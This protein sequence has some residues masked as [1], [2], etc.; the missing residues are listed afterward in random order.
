MFKP[1]SF[2][3]I[4]YMDG[5]GQRPQ[6]N[7]ATGQW[8]ET[9]LLYLIHEHEPKVWSK[10]DEEKKSKTNSTSRKPKSCAHY[11]YCTSTIECRVIRC[12]S[13]NGHQKHML[14]RDYIECSKYFNQ[15][16]LYSLWLKMIIDNCFKPTVKIIGM[17][18]MIVP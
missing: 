12:G 6:L 3:A 9:F 5:F 1:C 14:L 16:S 13:K 4:V 17:I 10:H 7:L 11:T 8:I 18:H 15:H 2:Y